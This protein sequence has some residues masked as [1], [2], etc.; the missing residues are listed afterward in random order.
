[1]FLKSA[2]AA[3]D[4]YG[5]KKINPSGDIYKFDMTP[6]KYNDITRI[7][8]VV[9]ADAE[10]IKKYAWQDLLD[11]EVLAKLNN[12]LQDEINK[13]KAEVNKKKAKR[14]MTLLKKELKK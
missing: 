8:Q 10:L 13:K 4:F 7:L 5:I 14:M 9:L 12:E 3:A 2:E 11:P 1:M 6:D